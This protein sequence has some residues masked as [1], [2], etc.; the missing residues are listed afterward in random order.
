M[1]SGTTRRARLARDDQT[2][3][4]LPGLAA[5]LQSLLAA[6]ATLSAN[7]A[8]VLAQ[9]DLTLSL[10]PT[11]PEDQAV[12]REHVS[13]FADSETLSGGILGSFQAVVT[14][15]NSVTNTARGL[16][17]VAQ[18]LDQGSTGDASYTS[19]LTAF[20]AVLTQLS[21]RTTALDPDSHSAAL[22]LSNAGTALA[23]FVQNQITDDMTRFQT[24]QEQAQYSGNID[25]LK[26]QI[27][28]LQTQIAGL[29]SDIAAGATTQI[30]PALEFGF[31]IGKEIAS[32]MTDP[33]EL[34]LSVGFAIKD[35]VDKANEFAAEMQKKN[36]DL[37]ALIG[38]YRDLVEALLT[39]EQEMAVL[40]SIAGHCTTYRDSINAA[41][42]FV[43]V[44]LGQIQLLHN[45]I[46]L[47]T[48]VDAS[49][50]PNF[51]TG[52]LNAAMT[53]WQA[54]AVLCGQDLQLARSLNPD[55]SS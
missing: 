16:L 13:L 25:R 39:D 28:S 6:Y 10:L 24:A 33:G 9:P 34:V 23:G 31:S 2:Y 37:D 26:L 36:D 38:Q 11:L 20:R 27:S 48:T 29:N 46:E 15:A 30:V 12:L 18:R 42:G 8:T 54:I 5:P 4:T 41:A 21:S 3:L 35:E 52:Q 22:P 47:L 53:A 45:G 7:G 14:I 49:D 19:D 44:I 50:S 43:Q 32:A 55:G 1:R 40:L 17:P 51:F